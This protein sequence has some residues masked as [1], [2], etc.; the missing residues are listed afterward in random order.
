MTEI[1]QFLPTL[2]AND[3]IGMHVMR[4]RS[5]L[6]DAGFGSEIFAEDIHDEMRGEA[7]P[8]L[9]YRR[10]VQTPS[11][12]WLLYHSSTGS[13][14]AEFLVEQDVPLLID[15]HNI[16]D[17]RYFER[18]APVIAQRMRDARDQLYRIAPKARFA[19]ADSSFNRLELEEAGCPRTAVAPILID[20]DDYRAEPHARTLARLRRERS[21]GGT[22][23]LFV[24][25]MAPNKCQHDVIAAFATYRKVFDPKAQLT[26]VGGMTTRSYWRALEALARE[27]ELGRDALVLADLVPFPALLAHYLT[28]DVFVCLSE[29]EGFNVPVLEAMHFGVPV[30]AYAVTATPETVGDAGLLLEDK[31]PLVVAAAVDRV[32]KD[33]AL[34]AS[35]TDAGHQRVEHFS[36]A[37]SGRRMIEAITLFLAVAGDA[38]TGQP[39]HSGA[40]GG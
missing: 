4:L 39:G 1:H 25:R 9:D 17:A 29:H 21:R 37:N 27:F 28:A 32:V 31:D 2:A 14:M 20:F 7:H 11:D 3:A 22:R 36:M 16:T 12:A 5:L 26:L 30:V 24:G 8:Y 13:Q 18:W 35:L 15:Y 6:R 40:A 33:P 23:W 34:R 10:Y 38:G 19:V